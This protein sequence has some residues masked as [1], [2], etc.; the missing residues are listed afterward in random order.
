[1]SATVD[2][3]RILFVINSLAGGGAE[4][5]LLELIGASRDLAARYDIALALLDDEPRAYPVPDWLRVHQLDARSGLARSLA[6]FVKLARAE[7]PAL[8]LSFLTRANIVTVAAARLLGHRAI[9]SERV[10]TSG[11]FGG[12]G[13]S[14]A[15]S[16][17]MVRLAYPR[18]D[19]VI[20]VSD[21]IAEDLAAHFGVAGGRIVTIANPVDAA[22]IRAAAA[23]QVA[24]PVAGPYAIAISRL[25]ANKNVMLPVEALAA[26]GLDWPLVVLGQG[27]ER[28]AILA[29]AA[30]LGIVD[31]VVMP[32]FAANPY[33]ALKGASLYLSGSRA[34][35]FPNGLVEALALGVPAIATNC[36]SGPAEILDERPREQIGGLT[37]GRHGILVPEDDVAAMAEAMRRL[38]DPTR[39]ARYA[40]AGPRRAADFGL[41]RAR[42]RYWAEIEAVLGAG[43]DRRRATAAFGARG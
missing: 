6:G 29:R 1:M 10:N 16:K 17:A 39:A 43:R 12:G 32:G 23:E 2:R 30:A 7:R 42:D 21:G 34:E 4:R 27:P 18:A 3:P 19:R 41:D 35:G 26:S 33:P 37:E 28:E 20:A 24:P 38:V 5:V 11:H 36:R 15:V 13:R 25:T 40:D 22:R 8:T 9:I 31:R 14:A